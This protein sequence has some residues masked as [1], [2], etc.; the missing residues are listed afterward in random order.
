[1]EA[2]Q[3]LP[4]L[5]KT[6]IAQVGRAQVFSEQMEAA[7]SPL[8]EE[9]FALLPRPPRPSSLDEQ[10][11]ISFYHL[12]IYIPST[13]PLP[14]THIFNLIRRHSN[15]SVFQMSNAIAL[16]GRRIRLMPNVPCLEVVSAKRT[17]DKVLVGV[18]DTN[19]NLERSEE[20]VE[21]PYEEGLAALE[22]DDE[23]WETDEE[24]T[25]EV[26]IVPEVEDLD[27]VLEVMVAP[28][29]E[30]REGPNEEGFEIVDE[31]HAF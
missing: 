10:V 15:L 14:S 2:I 28:E 17:N 8:S 19:G 11:P 9:V 22:D 16:I 21:I 7:P 24:E 27:E 6:R 18:K 3:R 1:M 29:L 13:L 30:P 26:E 4:T 23:D 31:E 12:C 5:L 20:I 25:L